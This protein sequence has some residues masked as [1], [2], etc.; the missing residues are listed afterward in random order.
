M[1]FDAEGKAVP[2]LK[3]KEYGT[4]WAEIC[5]TKALSVEGR[6]LGIDDIIDIVERDSAFYRNGNGGI[7]LSGGEPLLQENAVKLLKRAKEHYLHSAIE[8][9][10]AVDKER[11]FAALQ[12][13]DE[14]FFDIKSLNDE[15]H[16]KY[17]GISNKTI[18]ENLKDIYRRYPDKKITVRTPVI[19]GFNDDE[20]ELKRIEEFLSP[21]SNVTWERLPYHTYGV[22]KY[23]ML[24]RRYSLN[25]S[26]AG[27][28]G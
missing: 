7:T 22:A 17:T 21:F 5:P 20:E 25:D 18:L 6:Y 23:E 27:E 16:L 13:L 11:L 2:D 19:P 12:F 24:G 1:S 26:E 9:C 8:T 15:K 14:V 10:G 4:E 28:P 3:H